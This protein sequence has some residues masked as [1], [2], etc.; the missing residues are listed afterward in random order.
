MSSLNNIIR[1]SIIEPQIP[2]DNIY[3]FN[4]A[5]QSKAK[6]HLILTELE[7]QNL[8]NRDDHGS[9]FINVYDNVMTS[10]TC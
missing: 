7:K 4:V 1:N 2:A 6:L 3:S 5:L 8:E 10:K 9:A